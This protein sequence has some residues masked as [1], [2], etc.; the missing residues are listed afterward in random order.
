MWAGGGAA[1][2]LGGAAPRSGLQVAWLLPAPCSPARHYCVNIPETL[3]KLLLSVKWNS[4]DEVA[5][6]SQARSGGDQQGCLRD[7]GHLPQ[8]QD[9]RT[10]P[11]CLV[12]R[13][14]VESDASPGAGAEWQKRLRR[15]QRQPPKSAAGCRLMAAGSGPLGRAQAALTAV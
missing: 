14:A 9:R 12:R 8:P 5:Q 13:K 6:V 1:F 4:R 10:L 15:T 7:E 2:A 11:W 3:P